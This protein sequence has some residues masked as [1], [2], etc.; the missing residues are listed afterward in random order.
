MEPFY[1][2]SSRADVAMNEHAKHLLYKIHCERGALAH[3]ADGKTRPL[4]ECDIRNVKFVAGLWRVQNEF[5]HTVQYVRGQEFVLLNKINRMEKNRFEFYHARMV[6]RNCYG[7][8]LVDLPMIVAKYKTDSQT[9]WAYGNTIEQ[10][11]AFL[12]IRMY[13]EYSDVIHAA[14]CRDKKLDR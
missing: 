9:Y 5:P 8:F 10:A 7:P 12:G 4:S 1:S 14:A 11:R 3:S 6:G 13:D 2:I